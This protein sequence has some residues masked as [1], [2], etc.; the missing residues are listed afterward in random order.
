VRRSTRFAGRDPI[1]GEKIE[2][3]YDVEVEKKCIELAKQGADSDEIAVILNLRPGSVRYWYGIKIERELALKNLEV[4]KALYE[5]AVGFAHPDTIVSIQIPHGHTEPIVTKVPVTKRYP[6]NVH[7]AQFLLKNRG[8]GKWVDDPS[9]SLNPDDSA[10]LIRERL[11]Q[12]EE[13]G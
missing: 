6:P 9:G 8:R 2:H 3:K 4:E 10:K 13:A 11:R 7:A 5:N 1:T 12:M